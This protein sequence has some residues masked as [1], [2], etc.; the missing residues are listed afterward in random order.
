VPKCHSYTDAELF[1]VSAAVESLP[2]MPFV[3]QWNS[4]HPGIPKSTDVHS[5][6]EGESG[7]AAS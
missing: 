5:A 3:M 4:A 6:N 1:D 2:M 7:R